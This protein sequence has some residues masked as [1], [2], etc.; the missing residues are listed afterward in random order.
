MGDAVV[1][2]TTSSKSICADSLLSA[3]L[4]SNPWRDAAMTPCKTEKHM[5]TGLRSN[6]LTLKSVCKIVVDAL[7]WTWLLMWV[8]PDR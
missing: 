4:L 2:G 8:Q 5:Y 6:G 3:E 1:S 7:V